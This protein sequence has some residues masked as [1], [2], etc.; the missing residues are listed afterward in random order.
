MARLIGSFNRSLEEVKGDELEFEF[1]GEKFAV[2]QDT[3]DMPVMK[4]AAA[5]SSGLSSADMDGLAA[6]YQMIEDCLAPA[7][8]QRFY[9]TGLK[10]RVK[11]DLLLE[12]CTAIYEALAARPTERPSSSTPG[13]SRTTTK[14]KSKLSAT[15]SVMDMGSEIA[16]LKPAEIRVLKKGI[17]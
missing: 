1:F 6:M 12:I 8:W 2:A 13:R 3:G 4:F 11:A 15:D 14:S 10:H 9:A 7:D 16:E 5:A 17:G